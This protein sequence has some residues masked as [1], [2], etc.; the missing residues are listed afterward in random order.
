MFGPPGRAYVYFCYGMH[1]LLNVV[2][3]NAGTAGA[4]L[5]R[6]L[7][8]G[9]GLERMRINRGRNAREGLLDGPGKISR[10]LKI[11]LELNGWDLTRGEEL[12]ITRGRRKSGE[13]IIAGPRVGIRRG[14]ERPWRFRLV[15]VPE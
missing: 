12:Y 9:E 10:A 14:L 1:H 15:A 11:S 8:P 2:T 3:E 7:E 6:G 4:V 5:V 13:T